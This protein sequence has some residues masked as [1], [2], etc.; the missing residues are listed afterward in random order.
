M[1]QYCAA[2]EKAGIPTVALCFPDQQSFFQNVVLINGE[3]NVRMVATPRTGTGPERVATFL[4]ACLK[5]LTNPLTAKE[6]ETGIY[7]PPAQ[8][9]IAF[10]GTLDD[11]QTFFQA[12]TPVSNC[13]NCPINKWTDGLPII[14]PTEQKVKEML[15]GTSH[16]PDEKVFTYS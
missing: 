10:T 4:D 14:I 9:R 12:T 6:K 15:T 3:P 11:A 5:A 1:G 8:P 7:S 16:K 2:A 13:R